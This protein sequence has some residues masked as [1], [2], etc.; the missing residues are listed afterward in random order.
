[1]NGPFTVVFEKMPFLKNFEF[2]LNP[3]A[4]KVFGRPIAWYGLLICLGIILC[5]FFAAG[6]FR[7]EGMKTDDLLDYCLFAVP[8]GI[9]GARVFYVVTDLGS[10]KTFGEM[11][12]I[13]NG[14]LAITGGIV[15]GMITIFIVSRVKKQKYLIVLD[16][17]APGVIL[18]QAIGRWGN[19]FN[20]EVFGVE[21]SLPFAMTLSDGIIVYRNVHP[22]FLYECFFNLVGFAVM[23]LLYKKKKYN[24]EI[25]FFYLAWYGLIRAWLETLRNPKYNMISPLSGGLFSQNVCLIGGI[26]GLVLFVIGF[27][28]KKKKVWIFAAE[29]FAAAGAPAA[30]VPSQPATDPDVGEAATE[31]PADDG[32]DTEEKDGEARSQA[33][34]DGRFAADDTDAPTLDNAPDGDGEDAED[35]GD[36]DNS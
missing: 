11:L 5:Y 4:F 13:W 6:R 3:V 12:E 1:M 9:I 34:P 30:A 35:G 29:P 33:D 10:F 31:D 20:G 26:A 15:F 21:T 7:K 36:A 16:A 24:G 23:C 22:L 32:A 27:I 28:L 25:V 17:V 18:A 19:F 2:G 14:G 8:I